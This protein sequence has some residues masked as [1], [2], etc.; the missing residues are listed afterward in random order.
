M[1][2]ETKIVTMTL[3]WEISLECPGVLKDV[4]L[5]CTVFDT[6]NLSSKDV[7]VGCKEDCFIRDGDVTTTTDEWCSIGLDTSPIVDDTDKEKHALVQGI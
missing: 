1:N 3:W 6:V 4:A 7:A 2:K 5:I